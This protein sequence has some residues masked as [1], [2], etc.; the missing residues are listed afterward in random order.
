M[1][2]AG[3]SRACGSAAAYRPLG[4]AGALTGTTRGAPRR[5]RPRRPVHRRGRG[6]PPRRVV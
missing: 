5:W 1:N 6:F 3:A 2:P 4:R